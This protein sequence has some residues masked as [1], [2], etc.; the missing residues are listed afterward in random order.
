MRDRLPLARFAFG[1][2]NMLWH[3]K[4]SVWNAEAILAAGC[5]LSPGTGNAPL[6]RGSTA[7]PVAVEQRCKRCRHR[8]LP[9]A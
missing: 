9:P 8:D 5:R 6:V 4:R 7:S 1:R 3:N 2:N